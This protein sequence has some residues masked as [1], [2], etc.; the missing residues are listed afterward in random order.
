MVAEYSDTTKGEWQ[1]IIKDFEAANP[2]ITVNLSVVS[3]TNIYD[4]VT[5]NIQSGTPPDILNLDAYSPYAA[6]G[7]LYPAKD[8]VSPAVLSDFE[9]PFAE[10]STING[11]QWALPFIAS[12]R[13]LFYNKTIFAK[14]GLSAPPKTWAELEADAKAIKA[15]GYIGYGMPLGNEEA[16]AEGAYWFYGAGGGY[17]T[18]TS[19]ITIDTPQNIAGATEMQKLINAGLTEPNAGATNRDPLLNVFMAGKIG[20]EVGLPQ[21]VVQIKQKNPSLSYGVAAIP[22]ENGSPFTLGVEDHMM[23]FKSNVDKTAAIKKF[24]DYFYTGNVYT[25]WVADEGFL[26]VTT[27][28]ATAMASNTELKPFLAAL[29]YAVFYPGTNPKWATAQAALLSQL[30]LLA[31]PQTN[32][33]ALLKAIQAKVDK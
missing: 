13:A 22:T 2:T 32:P 15:A 29:P 26:P 6:S 8:I 27:T 21:T 23:A 19:K 28:G 9:R 25:T 17:G 4:V 24:L 30:G 3:W 10:E 5:T 16:Q 18:A 7:L 11:T 12:A 20:M 14:A 31:S 1:Q 33:S